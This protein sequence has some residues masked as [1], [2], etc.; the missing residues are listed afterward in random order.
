MDRRPAQHV[1]ARGQDLVPRAAAA[2][3]VQL[4]LDRHGCVRLRGPG[5]DEG[6]SAGPGCRSAGTASLRATAPHPTAD[7][8]TRGLRD[9]ILFVVLTTAAPAITYLV[10]GAPAFALLTHGLYEGAAPLF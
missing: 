1:A 2:R 6:A 10:V 8:A 9:R 5:R 4:R 3:G 7:P